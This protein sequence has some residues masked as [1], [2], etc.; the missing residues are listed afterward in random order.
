MSEIASAFLH[1]LYKLSPLSPMHKKLSPA[2]PQV[3]EKYEILSDTKASW[4]VY[5]NFYRPG[6]LKSV[7]PNDLHFASN[8]RHA[9][10][11]WLRT[12]SPLIPNAASVSLDRP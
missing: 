7:S 9:S 10:S 8:C 1:W 5:S 11:E 3:A 12:N 2:M 4:E 6:G